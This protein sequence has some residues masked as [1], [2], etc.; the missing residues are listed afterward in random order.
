MANAFNENDLPPTVLAKI[1]EFRG[2]AAQLAGVCK[3]AGIPV[4]SGLVLR[5]AGKVLVFGPMTTGA[6]GEDELSFTL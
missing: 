6:P 3:E 1:K 4:K 2:V 5:F